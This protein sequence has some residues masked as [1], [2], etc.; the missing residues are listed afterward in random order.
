VK[1]KKKLVVALS[2]VVIAVLLI[3]GILWLPQAEQPVEEPGIEPRDPVAE[4][5][6]QPK[7][8]EKPAEPAPPPLIDME[9]FINHP[10]WWIREWGGH[11]S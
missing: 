5:P 1:D 8:P 4:R 11:C 2:V 10:W 3:A 7:E 6:Q 9:M